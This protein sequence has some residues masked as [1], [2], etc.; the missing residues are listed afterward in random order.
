M[1]GKTYSNVYVM[2]YD[3]HII[4]DKLQA[5]IKATMRDKLQRARVRSRRSDTA[6]IQEDR[7]YGCGTPSLSMWLIRQLPWPMKVTHPVL[8]SLPRDGTNLNAWKCFVEQNGKWRRDREVRA[9]RR[10]YDNKYI[11][12]YFITS[13][14]DHAWCRLKIKAM[15]LGYSSRH[16]QGR[17]SLG[18]MTS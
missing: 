4:H 2:G 17:P 18:L 10:W 8:T 12:V 3:K 6:R 1:I 7:R 5:R 11:L 14:G 15:E 16:P 9:T 13:A